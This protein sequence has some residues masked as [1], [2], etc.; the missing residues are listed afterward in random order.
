MTARFEQRLS[1]LEQRTQGITCTCPPHPPVVFRGDPLPD[2]ESC[3][4]HG[5][6]QIILWP[7]ARSAVEACAEVSP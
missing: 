3:P 7:L 4:M 5:P 6:V 2:I 1:R